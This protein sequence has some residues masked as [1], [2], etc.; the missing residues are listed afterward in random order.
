MT[1][2]AGRWVPTPPGYVDAVEPSWARLRPFVMDSAGQF[3]SRPP[4][5]FDMARGSAFSRQTREVLE[6][7]RN[8]TE[9]Q[10]A[11][12]LFWDDNPYVMHVQGHAMF[13]TKK[14]TPGGHWMG[15][16]AIAARKPPLWRDPLPHG[17]R[18]GRAPGTPRGRAGG[19]PR[20]NPRRYSWRFVL[21]TITPLAPRMP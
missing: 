18:G 13:A 11:T 5:P 6:V 15:I 8:L 16:T 17:D 19:E 20:P 21:M 10:R 7:G 3:R 14:A 12:A 2:A 9:E 4:H 1:S